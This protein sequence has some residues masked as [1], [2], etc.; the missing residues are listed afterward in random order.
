MVKKK[1]LLSKEVKL[2]HVDN[3]LKLILEISK[4]KGGDEK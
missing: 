4:S 1:R 2:L 3:M